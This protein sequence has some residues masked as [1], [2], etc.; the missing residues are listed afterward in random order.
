MT[1]NRYIKTLIAMTATVAALALASCTESGDEPVTAKT[2]QTGLYITLGDVNDSRASRA[3]GDDTQYNP[4]AG[5][6]N[7]IDLE[8]RNI[9]VAF[10]DIDDKYLGELDE[11]D[12]IPMESVQNSK[13]YYLQGATKV[14]LSSGKFKVLVLANWPEYPAVMSFDN[15]W[16]EQFEY[17]AGS[18]PSA[19]NLIPLYGILD[20]SLSPSAI[21]PDINV[22]LGNIHLLRSLAKIEV[23]Y[24][25]ASD[26][27]TLSKLQLT[28]YNTKG[29]CGP[30]GITKQSDYVKNEWGLDYID[31][32]FI[33]AQPEPGNN[34][35]FKPI[36]G[37]P[38]H[39]ILYVPEYANKLADGTLRHEAERARLLVD[40]KESI[41]GERYSDIRNDALPGK[42]V[43][44]ILRNNWYK[45]T[46]KK[47]NE[48]TEVTF[49][50]D[51][52]PYKVVD[53]DPIFGL[54]KYT[55]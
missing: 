43:V 36:E 12:V 49:E 14:N 44:D 8:N 41:L 9:K 37:Q 26:S 10:Y 53:L 19:T 11:F 16:K 13:R 15:I 48:Q 25:D 50:V 29:F 3:P 45:I 28:N 18:M 24:E 38:N 22:N 4:G 6:E 35:D 21:K 1:L 5:Y 42:P 33:P 54:G 27:W 39:Y 20:V 55:G 7:Y 31:K 32:P 17:S 40:F 30:T 34:L 47:I 2:F 23:I 52:I 46:I 51:V